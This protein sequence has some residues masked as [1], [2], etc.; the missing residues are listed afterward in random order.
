MDGGEGRSEIK[1]RGSESA[2]ARKDT[3]LICN[4]CIVNDI[5][6]I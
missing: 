1:E 3:R 5:V 6:L 4:W 2:F